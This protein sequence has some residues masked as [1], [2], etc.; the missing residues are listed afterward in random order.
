[1]K[2]GAEA[3]KLRLI[4]RQPY[5]IRIFVLVKKREKSRAHN[6][7]VT[8]GL[9][10]VGHPDRNSGFNFQAIPFFISGKT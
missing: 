10:S 9:L 5:R 1:M 7:S 6:R 8:R 2:Q 3:L 4:K